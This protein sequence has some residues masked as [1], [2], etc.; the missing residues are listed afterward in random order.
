VKRYS[1]AIRYGHNM[2]IFEHR[3]QNRIFR[4]KREKVATEFSKFNSDVL[5]NLYSSPNIIGFIT[6]R[7]LAK[8]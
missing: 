3:V 7:K 8:E 4:P 5:H 2:R 6:S 1:H